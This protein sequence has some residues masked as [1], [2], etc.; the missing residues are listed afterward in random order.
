MIAV[1]SY[2]GG[3]FREASRMKEC[4]RIRKVGVVFK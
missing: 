3:V 2:L 1:V 4:T